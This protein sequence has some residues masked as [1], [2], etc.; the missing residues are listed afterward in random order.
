MSDLLAP[1]GMSLA[2]AG[3]VL[4]E[5]LALAE[6]EPRSCER[7]YYDTFDGLLH[8][9][10]LCAV[11]EDGV[12]A[13]VDER[14]GRERAR[15]SMP[16]PGGPLLAFELAPGPLREAL[17]RIVEV[18]ALLP[19]VEVS[20][21]VLGLDVLD[22]ERG[23]V[24]R[25]TLEQPELRDNG[26]RRPLR[27]RTKLA[28][29]RGSEQAL[30][31]VRATLGQELGFGEAPEPLVDE[32][33]RAAGRS[34]SGTSSKVQVPLRFDQR[35]DTAAAAI[36]VRLLEV[37]ECNIDGA[38][39]DLD[40][41]F[42][43]DMRVAVR[44][45]R[46]VQRELR[47]VFPRSEL[48]RFRAEFRRLHRVT[49]ESRDLDVYVL[50]FDSFRAMVPEA[51]RPDLD[52]LLGLLRARRERAHR[53][54]ADALR[55][56]PTPELFA[57]WRALLASL[58]DLPTADRRDAGLAIGVLAAR[59][60]GKVYAR[61][62]GIGGAITPT[63]APRDYHELRKQGKELRYLLELFGTPLYP[64][65]VVKPMIKALKALQDVLGRHQDREVQVAMLRSLCGEID[66]MPRAAG[67]LRAIGVL[68]E[69][70]GADERA[71]RAEFAE[72]FAA[73]SSPAQRRLV[74][75]A[76]G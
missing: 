74:E 21:R 11:H 46:S 20:S 62:V 73:F 27:L 68:V 14:A 40:S 24:V 64:S 37:I 50:E 66:E 59:R 32:A 31:G 3:K 8:G 45:T 13:L 65:E 55:S 19:L 36:L 70:L 23:T 57:R 75:D 28:P 18:R 56:P 7:A 38:L 43:H 72:R 25:I 52:P 26:R 39:A 58:A 35:A 17:E 9:A 10:G 60:I 67:A 53:A 30:A 1:A 34:P 48:E 49:G 71:A 4:H 12:L 54:M 42:L 69:R 6:R 41:E 29:V 47:H 5:H 16:R 2:A 61:M 22:G 76:F 51:M 15:A 63:S 44:R 33:A